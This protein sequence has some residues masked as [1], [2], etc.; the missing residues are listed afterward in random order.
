MQGKAIAKYVSVSPRKARQVAL[1]LKGKR[2]E[3]ALNILHFSVKTGSRVL[4]KTLRSAVANA[5]YGEETDRTGRGVEKLAVKEIRV[6]EG[7]M[8]KGI[9]PRA[10]GRA[11]KIRHRSSHIKVVV[12]D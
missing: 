7:P 3:D 8:R 5:M 4:E 10:M 12:T 11:T 6:D 1:L 2:V 9:R